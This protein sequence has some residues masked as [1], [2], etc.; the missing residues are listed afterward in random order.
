M[1]TA[2]RFEDEM[3]VVGSYADGKLLAGRMGGVGVMLFNQPDKRNAVNLEMWDG[4]CSAI[5]LFTAD[6]EVR[7][8][9]YGG[10]GGEAFT[11]GNDISQFAERRNNAEANAEFARIAGRGREKM[12]AFSKPSIACIEGYC[13]GG[14]LATALLADFR[15]SASDAIFGVPAARLGIAYAFE[16]MERLV[17]AVGTARA[18]LMLYTARRFSAA[19]ALSMGLVDVLAEI[20]VVAETLEIART[21][22]DNAPL[23]VMAAKHS[24]EQLRKAPQARDLF[25]I[26]EHMRRCM[27]SADY[28]E[29]R[30]AFLE[31]RR[32]VFVGA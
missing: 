14:G 23:S 17:E 20:D 28:R 27:D 8:V 5:D 31:K 22:A 7:V 2:T 24:F 19:E 30:A 3:Q 4:V 29:G 15:V 16:A 1:N 13:L 6:D 21:I 18:S 32:P 9:V 10:A 12:V 11:S 26:A 25:A